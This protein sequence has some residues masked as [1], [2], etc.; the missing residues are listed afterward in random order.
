V[1]TH[2]AQRSLEP[3]PPANVGHVHRGEI[4]VLSASL[5]ARGRRLADRRV[6]H[7][8][9]IGAFVRTTAAESI[10]LDH[11][12]FPY[13]C[14]C[15]PVNHALLRVSVRAMAAFQIIAPGNRTMATRAVCLPVLAVTEHWLSHDIA[16]VTFHIEVVY[17]VRTLPQRGI[18]QDPTW[19][20]HV[21][22]LNIPTLDALA[23]F[24]LVPADP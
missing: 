18:I 4:S 16:P 24:C 13:R 10:E 6:R 12:F 17:M 21:R 3:A 22:L 19:N 14:C 15:V 2:T 20:V 23:A 1:Y 11:L 5:R 8:R 7:S 9:N